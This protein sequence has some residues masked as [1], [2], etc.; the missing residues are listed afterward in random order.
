M[1]LAIIGCLGLG[2][3][4]KTDL[5]FVRHAETVANATGRYNGRTL[6]TLSAEGGLQ[7]AALTDRL[8]KERRWDMILVSP[9]PRAMRTIAPYLQKTH[10]K[11]QIW[12]LLYECCTERPRQK[13]AAKFS[14]GSRIEV[15]AD[16][17][18]LFEIKPGS[19][20]YPAPRNYGEGLAQVQ[21]ALSEFRSKYAGRRILLVGHSAHGGL[22]L[23]G[24]DG[25]ARRVEN[26]KEIHLSVSN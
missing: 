19:D 15:P 11:A 17:A 22:F 20:R 6:N 12:P 14:Y 1:Y 16:L 10:Q 5:T 25:K 8:L 24:L 2:I 21:A 13:A 7:V 9:A 26:A 4:A 23:K 18:P 3:Q